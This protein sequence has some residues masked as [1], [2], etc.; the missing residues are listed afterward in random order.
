MSDPR[1]VAWAAADAPCLD[2]PLCRLQSCLLCGATP[3]HSG[4]SCDAHASN[5]S[6]SQEEQA[7]QRALEADATT[8][9]CGGCNAYV[10]KV[11]GCDKFQCIC[12]YRFCWSCGAKDAKCDCTGREHTFWDNV[13]NEPSAAAKAA[14][15]RKRRRNPWAR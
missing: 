8:R 15:S 1:S 6:P 4:I 11:E 13:K 12:G 7:T 5:V 14:A 9:Q 2:C 3:Y 10:S